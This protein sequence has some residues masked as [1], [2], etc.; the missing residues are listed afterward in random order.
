MDSFK[1]ILVALDHTD[2]DKQL[3]KAASFLST[4]AKSE[5][6]L[7]INVI[8]STNIPDQIKKEFPN[9][10]EDA[11]KERQAA[12]KLKVDQYFENNNTKV[13]IEIKSGQPTKSILKY[14][15]TKK[16]DL[17]IIG[18]KNEHKGGG[19]LI[20]RIARRAGCSLLIIP[21][22]FDKKV[23]KILVP[24]DYSDHSLD[25]LNQLIDLSKD[26]MPKVKMIPQ[27]VYQV[28]SGYHYA[29]KTFGDFAKIMEENS[30]KEYAAFDAKIVKQGMEIK[31]IFTLDRDEDIISTIY[32]TAKK[33]RANAIVIG[34]KGVTSTSALFLGSSA[35][36]LIQLDSEIP[37]FV[38]RAK[39][40]QKNIIEYL[41]K[42]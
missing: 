2:I 27:N 14:S 33:I 21:K 39:G 41:L 35:E 19:V 38:M 13:R 6:V 17:I 20:H 4:L 32:A 29:G 12:I 7:F 5:E 40:K 24:I 23:N 42:L 31:P 34:A 16:I 25:S 8:K 28:P 3:I 11:L 30:Q 26:K 1:K 18:R 37:L 22:G 10:M 9:L 36:K 15:A